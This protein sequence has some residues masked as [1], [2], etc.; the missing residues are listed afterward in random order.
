MPL[1]RANLI[2]SIRQITF[3]EFSRL[4]GLAQGE[5]VVGVV[6]HDSNRAM[7]VSI[8]RAEMEPIGNTRIDY[9]QFPANPPSRE[10][11]GSIADDP[12]GGRV[13]GYTGV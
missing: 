6:E 11:Q 13:R 9:G 12:A 2:L 8:A 1:A 3:E 4:L 5:Q 7:K 10:P